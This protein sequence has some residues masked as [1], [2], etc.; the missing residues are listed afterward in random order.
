MTMPRYH[1]DAGREEEDPRRLAARSLWI[2][3]CSRELGRRLGLVLREGDLSVASKETV[4]LMR[5]AFDCGYE[6]GRREPEPETETASAGREAT[7]TGPTEILV[8]LDHLLD[9]DDEIVKEM[10]K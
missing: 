4:A 7:P 5:W 1:A 9:D 8:D 10:T 6:A 2:S 3:K